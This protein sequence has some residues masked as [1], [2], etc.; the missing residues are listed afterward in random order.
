M[1]ARLNARHQEM[2]RSKIRAIRL[3]RILQ[4]EAEGKS[5]LA[6]GQRDS[7]KF[8]LNKSISNAPTIVAGAGQNGAHKIEVTVAYL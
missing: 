4:D 8:L 3:I 5:K 6:D 1:A 7:A 2:V